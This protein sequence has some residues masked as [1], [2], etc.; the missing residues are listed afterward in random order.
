MKPNK[1]FY[2]SERDRVETF[3]EEREERLVEIKEEIRKLKAEKATI[4]ADIK[5][6]RIH[7]KGLR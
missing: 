7:L 4:K 5:T 3:I 2:T 6:S 1:T